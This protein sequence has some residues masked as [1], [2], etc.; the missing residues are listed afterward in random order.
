MEVCI[1]NSQ[2]FHEGMVRNMEWQAKKQAQLDAIYERER[3][4]YSTPVQTVT[5]YVEQKPVPYSVA[6]PIQQPES[7]ISKRLDR[8]ETRID[9][10]Y[11]MFGN[12]QISTCPHDKLFVFAPQANIN[13]NQ[14]I[15]LTDQQFKILV[16]KL[17]ND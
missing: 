3:A 17:M 6:H 1:M 14:A 8:I 9:K 2:D 5:T 4:K 15:T 11:E 13:A 12:A 7:D 10:L 16:D